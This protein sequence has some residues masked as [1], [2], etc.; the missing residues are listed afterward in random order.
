[1]NTFAGLLVIFLPALIQ[2]GGAMLAFQLFG[3]PSWIPLV[4]LVVMFF[5]STV[6]ISPLMNALLWL[7]AFFGLIGTGL[8]TIFW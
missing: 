6:K 4:Y 3:L 2:V 8:R 5:F 7:L 1:M